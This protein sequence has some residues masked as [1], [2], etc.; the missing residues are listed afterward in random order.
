MI[1]IKTADDEIVKRF[2]RNFSLPKK[3]SHKGENG[4]LLIIGG[5]SLFHSAPLWSAETASYF[6]DLVHFSSTQENEKI[7]LSLKKKFRNGI[8]IKKKDLDEYAREDD[9]IL[10]GSGLVRGTVKE[11]KKKIRID[12]LK[13]IL[14]LDNEAEYTYLLTKYL[15]EKYPQKKFVFDAGS[16]QMM[17]KSW[18]LKLK[19][20]S[21]VT[22]HQKEF[23]KLFSL[24]VSHL[25]KKE[26]GQMVKIAA[27][28]HRTVILLKAVDDY[29]SD[30]SRLYVIEGGNQGL[31]KGG[32]GD[33]LA[34]LVACFYTKNP[35]LEAAV[36]SSI[37]LKRTADELFARLGYWYNVST[38]IAHLPQTLKKIVSI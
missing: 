22:P 10:V 2:F 34:S 5:S 27:K 20:P 18:L 12:N 33:V 37:L 24:E 8:V 26:K 29:I 9:V 36:F 30:G 28:T 38:I 6:V 4:K 16:L 7:F 17:E 32:T 15:I 31:T 3:G 23:E 25:D 19:T 21:I 35:P 14:D 11:K 1:P 13:L